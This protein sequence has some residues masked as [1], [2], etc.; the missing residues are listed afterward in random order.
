MPPQQM[1]IDPAHGR[2]DRQP[3]KADRDHARDDL[4][5]P[6]ELPRFKDPVA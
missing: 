6:E 5:G 2:I 3:E 4:V 1:V